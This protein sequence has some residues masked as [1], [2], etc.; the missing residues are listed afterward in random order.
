M[1]SP[2]TPTTSIKAAHLRN[3]T[4]KHQRRSSF[5]SVV[6]LNL[7]R[8]RVSPKTPE[9]L[10]S[11][12]PYEVAPGIWNTDA[13]AKVFGYL[14]LA[15]KEKKRNRSTASSAR[16]YSQIP[17]R[18]PV[19]RKDWH[20]QTEEARENAGVKDL[21]NQ[22]TQVYIELPTQPIRDQENGPPEIVVAH[23]QYTTNNKKRMR[24]VSRDDQLIERGANPRTGLVSPFVVSDSSD[25]NH[26]HDYVNVAKVQ[27]DRRRLPKGRTRSRK[28]KQQGAGWSL[29]ESPS[30]SP[31]PQSVNGPL[32][33]K[34]SVKQLEDKL[35]VAM[36]GVDDPEPQNMSETQIRRYQESIARAYKYGGRNALVDPEPLPSPRQSTPDGPS[37][38]PNRL[39]RLRRKV[40][41]SGPSRRDDSNDTVVVNAKGRVSPIPVLEA[42]NVELPGATDINLS[43]AVNVSSSGKQE[44]RRTNAAEDDF[45]DQRNRQMSGQARSNA[46]HLSQLTPWQKT[47]SARPNGATSQSKRE[48]FNPASPTLSQRLPCLS[49]L[50][51]SYFADLRTS[52]YRRPAELLAERVRPSEKRKQT[53]ENACTTIITSTSS[54]EQKNGNRPKLQRQ[55]ESVVT[56]NS[57]QRLPRTYEILEG[58][59]FLAGTLRKKPSSVTKHMVDASDSNVTRQDAVHPLRET[60]RARKWA[61]ARRQWGGISQHLQHHSRT[62]IQGAA[63][64]ARVAM[65]KDYHNQQLH[66]TLPKL[67]P[68]TASKTQGFKLENADRVRDLARIGQRSGAGI[69]HMSVP[70]GNDPIDNGCRPSRPEGSAVQNYGVRKEPNT[71]AGIASIHKGSVCFTG[72]WAENLQGRLDIV[73]AKGQEAKARKRSMFGR[74]VEAKSRFCAVMESP[75]TS[76]G[77]RYVHQHV[78]R[79]TCHISRTLHPESPALKA[80]HS[81]NAKVQDSLKAAKDLI[82]AGI[83]LYLMLNILLAFWKVL[84][85]VCAMVFWVWHLVRTVFVL[86][87][88]CIQA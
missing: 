44:G 75:Q 62:P 71:S 20:H 21:N 57:G 33:R 81:P 52:S 43:D 72:Q 23:N 38:P 13:T 67:R 46:H 58:N 29:V 10:P 83:Y 55:D 34:V 30:L 88:W 41:G 11:I 37:T 22:T 86:M 53:T 65:T 3:P 59:C 24:T 73:A 14:E 47:L 85:L 54:R 60:A 9:T 82:V 19:A 64:G 49:F 48:L 56:P 78:Y 7:F 45:L 50:H 61:E 70:L 1:S 2:P 35:L 26:S 77:I 12:E 18:K 42:G 66:Q 69:T 39:Q 4:G 79:M 8:R 40:V 16:N 84:L 31:I 15:K 17:K 87:R 36:P 6:A 76:A 74:V 63:K 32:S 28:W 80:L 51:P 27:P 5:P 68:S 25:D